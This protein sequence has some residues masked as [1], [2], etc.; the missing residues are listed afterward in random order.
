MAKLAASWAPPP[1]L[2]GRVTC[3][4]SFSP[5][6]PAGA[7]WL[8]PGRAATSREL[9]AIPVL[10]GLHHRYAFPSARPFPP[11]EFLRRTATGKGHGT[12]R[13]VLMGLEGEMPETIDPDQMGPRVDRIRSEEVLHLL[14]RR[15]IALRPSEHL[16]F[17]RLRSLP[18]HPNG[19]RFVASDAAGVELARAD[20]LLGWRR[21]RRWRVDEQRCTAG[22][23]ARGWRAPPFHHGR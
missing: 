16:I 5:R 2:E 12:D 9:T 15:A 14:G 17:H 8:G 7:R 20:V 3:R 11:P 1:L 21:V 10:G 4:T 19:M 6:H 23:D 18:K 13:A 22:T